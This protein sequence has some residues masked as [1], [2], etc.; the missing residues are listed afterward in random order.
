MQDVFSRFPPKIRIFL[1]SG[2][3]KEKMAK[4]FEALSC[5]MRQIYVPDL[6]K[7]DKVAAKGRKT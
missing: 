4:S 6:S 3:G 5:Q 7:T 1:F 2:Q